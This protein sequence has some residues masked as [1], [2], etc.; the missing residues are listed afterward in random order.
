MR[1]AGLIDS[2]K[3]HN[4]NI[5]DLGD[6]TVEKYFEPRGKI[7]KPRG[8][9]L[10]NERLAEMVKKAMHTYH[11]VINLGG[12][13]S[14]AMG[15][16]SGHA[17][18]L[19]NGKK[20]AVIWVDAHADINT[21]VSSKSGNMHGQPVS[22]LME[23]FHDSRMQLSGFDWLNPSINGNDIAYIGLR[24][25]EPAEVEFLK[26]YDLLCKTST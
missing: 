26:R 5:T 20:P 10:N 25:V 15:T 23:E 11:T 1:E 16:V 7:R 17:Q 6:I 9:G 22:F 12:D 13:H 24:D 19:Y 2:L 8:V 3:R 14:M 18:S 4:R 21:P